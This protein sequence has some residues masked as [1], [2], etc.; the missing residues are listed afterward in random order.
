MVDLPDTALVVFVSD[1]H[2]GGD[3][4]C[5]GFES[6]KELEALF[7]ELADREG[8]VELILAGDFFDFLQIGKVPKGED[9]A[10]LTIDRSE[11]RELFAALKRFRAEPGKRVIYLPGNHD[12]ES[13][14]NKEIQETLRER[15]LVD[16]FAY[17]YLASVE[18]G[19]GQRV[20]YCEHGNQ[21]DPENSVGDYLDPLD[22]P[23]GHHVVMDGTRRIAPF[24]EI[25]S[26]LDLSEIKMVY[27]LVAIPAW[28]ASRYFYNLAGKVA[29]YLLVPLLVAY[30]V[31]KVVAYLISRA[32]DGNASLLFGSYREL[33]QVHQA[34]LDTALFLLL[35]LGIFGVFFLVVRHAVHRT[36]RVVSPGGTPHYSPAEASQKR[37][38][39]VLAGEARPP[40]DPAFDP[41]TADVFVS[42]HTHLPSLAEMERPD[43][44][45]SVLVNSGCFLRQLQPIK[46]RLKGPP[47]FVSR[48]VLTHVRVFAQGEK[49]RVELWEQ[50]KPAGQT[51]TRIER[52]VSMGRR[53]PQPPAGAKP[54][55]V[56][57]A[58]V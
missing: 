27:P 17:Y 14:W 24:G 8:P 32:T 55:L 35:V 39:A 31:Y 33:P 30:A 20:V 23:L 34:F 16:E 49:L 7:V 53:P 9:R 45:T 2:I 51:L 47:I 11:Y 41:T 58:T 12:A 5:D 43:G 57:S 46:P 48:F 26:G 38:R 1:S 40:M 44:S 21:F 54:R 37:I 52:L 29:S 25:S 28:I 36:L 56:A 3:P 10:S 42:G 50:P 13:F 19:G 15:G 4:G 22:T 6:P 18:T